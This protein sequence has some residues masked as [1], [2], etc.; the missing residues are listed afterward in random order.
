MLKTNQPYIYEVKSGEKI[1]DYISDRDGFVWFDEADMV[2]HET[3]ESLKDAESSLLGYAFW[4]Y[5]EINVEFEREQD[6]YFQFRKT[7]GTTN[8]LR[9]PPN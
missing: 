4:L 5:S 9:L 7:T 1:Q 2:N 6:G 8:Y 3:F